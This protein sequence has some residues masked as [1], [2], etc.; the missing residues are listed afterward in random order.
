MSSTEEMEELRRRMEVLERRV[1]AL[2]ESSNSSLMRKE[3]PSTPDVLAQLLGSPSQ[4]D[5]TDLIMSEAQVETPLCFE[6]EPSQ[7]RG[8]GISEHDQ[9]PEV[10]IETPVPSLVGGSDVSVGRFPPSPPPAALDEG[11]GPS[12]VWDAAQ[13]GDAERKANPPESAPAPALAGPL[14]PLETRDAA[15]LIIGDSMVRRAGFVAA[16][17]YRLTVEGRGGLTW[18]RGQAWVNRQVAR[19]RATARTEGLRLDTVLVWA[20]GNDAYGTGG[21][22]PVGIGPMAELV[23]ELVGVVGSI[24]LMG[25]TPRPATDK[26]SKAWNQTPAFLYEQDMLKLRSEERGVRVATVGRQ[27]CQFRNNPRGYYVNKD[28]YFHRDGVH[29]NSA[30]YTRILARLPTWLSAS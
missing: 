29:L 1:A 22:Q 18:R 30:G 11:A 26:N 25:P 10:T 8:L 5:I 14:P 4:W 27:L 28:K 2:E 23:A 21:G 15:V 20:G 13:A 6:S 7:V 24:I 9:P 16:A 3:E 12:G 19:W 17:P